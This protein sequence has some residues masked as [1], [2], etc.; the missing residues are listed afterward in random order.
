MASQAV[1][2]AKKQQTTAGLEKRQMWVCITVT[3]P[4][5]MTM[6]MATVMQRTG[7][8]FLSEID[9][10]TSGSKII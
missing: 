3:R 6:T 9:V 7:W 2:Q 10:K 1:L 8:Q 4:D 5:G